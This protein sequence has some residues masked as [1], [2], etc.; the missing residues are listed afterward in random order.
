MQQYFAF[1]T[2]CH[3]LVARV[4]EK[5][6]HLEMVGL[7]YMPG[8]DLLEQVGQLATIYTR[9]HWWLYKTKYF[10]IIGDVA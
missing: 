3:I 4:E 1:A 6:G 9:L 10:Y 7:V 5:C 2:K 8:I